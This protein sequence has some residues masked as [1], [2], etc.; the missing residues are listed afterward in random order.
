[1]GCARNKARFRHFNATMAQR[2]LKMS[3][4]VSKELQ[5]R[6]G[7]KRL[8]VHSGDEVIVM[9]GCHH[10]KEGKITRVKRSKYGIYIDKVT[11]KKING[12]SVQVP[13]KPWNC[14]LTKLKMDFNRKQLIDRRATGRK[15][16]LARQD[17]ERDEIKQRAEAMN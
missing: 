4:P 6:Y 13:L 15:S 16:F 14:V 12:T 9:K 8:P 11:V 17:K 1:M 10:D 5:K 3:A 7:I 2:R